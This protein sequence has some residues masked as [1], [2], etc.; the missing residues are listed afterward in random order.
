M[1]GASAERFGLRDRG[2]LVRGKKADVV[3]FD[4][5]VVDESAPRDPAPAGKPKGI[6]KVFINGIQVVDNGDYISGIR[7]GEVIRV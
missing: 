3:I 2:V 6:A 4:P 7:A 5:A 1:T